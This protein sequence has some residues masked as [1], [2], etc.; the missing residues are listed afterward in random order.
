MTR[1][2]SGEASPPAMGIL[3]KFRKA[4]APQIARPLHPAGSIN[5]NSL[6]KDFRSETERGARTLIDSTFFS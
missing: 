1:V 4:G 3:V 6:C 5:K 2:N